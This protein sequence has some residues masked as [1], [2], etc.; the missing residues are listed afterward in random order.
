VWF[1]SCAQKSESTIRNSVTKPVLADMSE[2]Q[3]SNEEWRRK[4]T[5]EQFHVTCEGGTE[6]A[7]TGKYW[8]FHKDGIYYC[9]RC[10]IPLFDSNTK[11][12]S[13]SGWPSFYSQIDSNVEFRPDSSSRMIRTE[14]ICK[15]CDSHLG[16]I[17]DD[18]PALTKMRYCVNSISLGFKKR[19]EKKIK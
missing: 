7:F 10:G 13:G 12:E 18:G 2:V 8:D 9:V 19:E 14:I 3:L 1:S 11:F 5:P 17:F 16:H 6:H 15:R 4:L